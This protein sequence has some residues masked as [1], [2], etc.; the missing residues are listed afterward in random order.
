M[1]QAPVSEKGSEM[2]SAI[3]LQFP[4]MPPPNRIR[5]LRLARD[6]SQDEL[7]ALVGCSKM[8]ISGLER[9]KPRLDIVWMQ[10]LAPWLGCNPG[11][12]L[13]PGDN[14]GAP[15]D[16]AERRLLDLYRNADPEEQ[17]RIL[18]V[19]EALSVYHGREEAA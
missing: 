17:K 3:I 1:L 13:N 4:T 8:Q 2:M 11:D 14:P 16:A 19:G 5:E 9:G 15:Q 18:A 12:L 6:M 7:A 10:R